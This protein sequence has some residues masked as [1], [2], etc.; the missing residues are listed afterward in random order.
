MPREMDLID[1]SQVSE[2]QANFSAANAYSAGM[3]SYVLVS[4]N[5]IC[6]RN[7]FLKEDEELAGKLT[8]AVLNSLSY[9]RN[10]PNI[11]AML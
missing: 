7:Q 9:Q 5:R 8:S 10:D 6:Q 2:K 3:P 4:L 1:I 11:H